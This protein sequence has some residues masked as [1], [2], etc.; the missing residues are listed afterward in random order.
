MLGAVAFTLL[1]LWKVL[2]QLLHIFNGSELSARVLFQEV[3]LDM[4]LN[5]FSN[6]TVVFV[7]NVTEELIVMLTDH[8][9][10]LL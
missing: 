9:F 1:E 5:F 3:A 7:H 10:G 8:H 6:F 2:N 4:L